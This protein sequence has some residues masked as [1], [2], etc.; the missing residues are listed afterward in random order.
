M[1]AVVVRNLLGRLN[2]RGPD[3]LQRIARFWQVS[4]RGD[5]RARLVGALYRTMTDIRSVRDAWDRLPEDQRAMARLLALSDAPPMTIEAMAGGLDRSPEEARETAIGLFRVGLLAR[6]G[7]TQELPVGALPRLVLPREL[8][9]LVRRVQDEIDAGDLSDH[10]LRVLL[11]VLDDAELE[12]SADIWG[13]KVIPGL[14]RRSE[15]IGQILRQVKDASRIER[16]AATLPRDA[17]SLWHVVR[18]NAESGPMSLRDA[19]ADGGF[20]PPD[21]DLARLDPWVGGRIRAALA[22]LEGSL[23]VWHGYQS[24]E[25]VLFLPREIAFPD[26]VAVTSPLPVLEPI[27]EKTVTAPEPPFA[28][29]LAW[30]LLT[31]LR[32]VASTGAPT[33][34]PGEPVSRTWQRRINRRLWFAGDELPPP[35]YLGFLLSLGLAAGVLTPAE[36]APGDPKGA[37]RPRVTAQVRAWRGQSFA[38]HSRRLRDIWLSQ[39]QW[40]E[41]REREEIDVWGA[42]WRGFRP[43]LLTALDALPDEQWV[44]LTAAAKQIAAAN[45][46]LIGGTFTAASARSASGDHEQA[47]TDALAQLVAIALQTAGQWFGLV[48][49]GM[50]KGKGAVVRLTPAGRRTATGEDEPPDHARAEKP[51]LTVAADGAITLRAPSPLRIWSLSAFADQEALRPEARFQLRPVS[52]GRALGAGFDLDQIT[53]FL[54]RQSGGP[55]P[56]QLAEV[57]RTWAEGYRRVRLRRAVVLLPDSDTAREELAKELAERAD[58]GLLVIDEAQFDKPTVDPG[59]PAPLLVL[60]PATGDDAERAERALFAFLSEA[61]YSGQWQRLSSPSIAERRPARS[62]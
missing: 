26:E 17:A 55:L 52:V 60:L 59:D 22:D 15:L 10:S 50:A 61:G 24:G 4:V 40:I 13:L 28:H 14:R 23:L 56:D 58:S 18:G 48:Q 46:A 62:S 53:T 19:L 31:V 7:D 45:P 27:P 51:A 3:D 38:A 37:I 47:R 21:Q 25:R 6:E 35:G 33:W 34:L 54:E 44:S 57:L 5:D 29:A 12:Q 43:R 8:A 49:T 20:V 9:A 11:E 16:V 36:P 41:G 42:D 30:D 32:E 39:D 1:G 2:A